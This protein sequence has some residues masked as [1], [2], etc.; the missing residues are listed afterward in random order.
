[1]TGVDSTATKDA[2]NHMIIENNKKHKL[3]EADPTPRKT[4]LRQAPS[5]D[6]K[7]SMKITIFLG[8][9]NHF[10][11]SKN[12]VSTTVIIQVKNQKPISVDK[13]AWKQETLIL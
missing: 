11:L 10:Y 9:D 4:V 12:D 2:K 5:S 8:L 6:H 7:Y 13:K 1:V 3:R